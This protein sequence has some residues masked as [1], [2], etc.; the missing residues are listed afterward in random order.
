M[1]DRIKKIRV[2]AGLNQTDFAKAL[3]IS[4]SAV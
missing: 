3:S 1:K 4:R 2:D